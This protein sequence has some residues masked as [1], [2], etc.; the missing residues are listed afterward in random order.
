MVDFSEILEKVPDWKVYYT[1]DELHE[2]SARLANEYPDQVELMVLGSSAQG[3]DIDC[4]KIGD[5]RYNALIHGFPNC[6]EP[7]G[8]NLLDY[9]SWAL[10]EHP[11]VA[12][13]L[14]YT[15]YLIK[16]SDPDGARLNE[17]FHGGPHTPMNFTLN[18]YRTPNVKTPDSCFPFRFGPLDL[19]S[20]VPETEAL[21][22]VLDR[23]PMSFVSALHMMKWGGGITYEVPH[24]CPEL[25]ASLWDAAKRFDV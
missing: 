16:C 6:E 15:W 13:K 2:S 25:Y 11:K 10:V 4:L 5:G 7:F 18:Y 3:E 20:P 22:K 19:N 1:V 14:D 23:V 24:R 17:G 12:E 21:M 9:L 8:G